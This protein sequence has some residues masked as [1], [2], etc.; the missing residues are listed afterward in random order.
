VDDLSFE[1]GAG[2]VAGFLGPDGAGKTATLRAPPGLV[3][4]AG[5]SATINGKP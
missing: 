3:H 2:T 4:P 1:V 5:G